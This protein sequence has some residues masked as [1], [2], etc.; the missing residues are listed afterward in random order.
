MVKRR[1]PESLADEIADLLDTRPSDPGAE[2]ELLG[3]DDDD[4]DGR[5]LLA[6]EDRMDPK[7][8]M[9]ARKMRASGIDLGELGAKYA[10]RV[11]SRA[12]IERQGNL[13][14][15]PTAEA[16]EEEEED[17][18]DDEA[19]E[20]GGSED[21]DEEL[22]DDDEDD[23]DDGGDEDDDGDDEELS[24]AD[25]DDDDDDDAASGNEGSAA[26]DGDLY[27]QWSSAQTEEAALLTQLK[28]TQADEVSHAHQVATQ[29]TAW[30]QLLQLR[31]KMQRAL[32]AAARWPVQTAGGLWSHD[33]R[34]RKAAAAAATES[35]TLLARLCEVRHA[36]SA[37]DGAANGVANGHSPA[38]DGADSSGGEDDGEG[39]GGGDGPGKEAPSV[40]ALGTDLDA[41]WKVRK[42]LPLPSQCISAPHTCLLTSAP[43]M[44]H[45]AAPDRMPHAARDCTPHASARAG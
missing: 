25:D 44:P 23:E 16:E 14:K 32:T 3:G 6:P 5:G 1:R 17:D 2:E 10:G 27:A 22:D 28:Q 41:W 4:D 12:K 13:R 42:P 31:I 37:D 30:L 18:D 39:G 29:H 19:S 11:T 7:A 45:R 24:D 35:A 34:A 15:R 36:L 26:E 38:A 43:A 20:G 21:D 40:A 8:V 33:A 9:P